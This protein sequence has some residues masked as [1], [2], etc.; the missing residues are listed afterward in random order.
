MWNP[1]WVEKERP[2]LSPWLVN[3][4]SG[5]WEGCLGVSLS[6]LVWGA[7]QGATEEAEMG[8]EEDEVGSGWR[9]SFGVV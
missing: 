1:E 7:E 2:E 8:E 9:L 3:M 6:G 4:S 5:S